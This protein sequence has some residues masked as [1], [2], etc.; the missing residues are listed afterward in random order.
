MPAIIANIPMILGKEYI[1]TNAGSGIFIVAIIS[2]EHYQ[3][4]IKMDCRQ[5]EAATAALSAI[6]NYITLIQM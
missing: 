3:E 1:N 5:I 6:T 2:Q 4:I